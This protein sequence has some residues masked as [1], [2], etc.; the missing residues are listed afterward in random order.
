MRRFFVTKTIPTS[1][2]YVLHYIP[3]KSAHGWT[4]YARKTRVG[5]FLSQEIAGVHVLTLKLGLPV[6]QEIQ[7]AP[8]EYNKLQSA[9]TLL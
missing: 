5:G 3:S 8:K 2:Q 1:K 9:L 4:R 7:P 6:M